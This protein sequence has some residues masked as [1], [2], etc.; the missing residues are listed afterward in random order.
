MK[1]IFTI[2]SG[3][4]VGIVVAFFVQDWKEEKLIYTLTEPATFGAISFQNLEIRNEGF[5]PATNVRLYIPKK[6]LD[7][8]QIEL[9]AKFDLNGDGQSIVGGLERIR[10]GESVLISLT[11]KS[12]SASSD[13]ITIK[14]DRSIAT[15]I[16]HNAWTFDKES[17]AIGAA[18]GI[19][20]FFF[21]AMAIGIPAYKEYQRKA[22]AALQSSVENNQA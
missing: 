3:V 13:D 14:S 16:L 12:G 5:D 22:R 19:L 7:S 8:K 2:L 6:I 20:F 4:I 11:S 9:V 15:F 18:T 10:R 17:F 21:M 1:F